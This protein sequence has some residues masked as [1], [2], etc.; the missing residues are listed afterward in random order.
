MT[1]CKEVAYNWRVIWQGI[2]ICKSTDRLQFVI[3][4]TTACVTHG[5]DI[6]KHRYSV[7]NGVL[8]YLPSFL[9]AILNLGVQLYDLYQRI[10][11][12]YRSELLCTIGQY[13]EDLNANTQISLLICYYTC[14][15]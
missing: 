9:L 4:P 2:S 14:R 10:N 8:V 5:Q 7:N 1:T 11:Y 3:V 13:H 6:S 12:M 15:I